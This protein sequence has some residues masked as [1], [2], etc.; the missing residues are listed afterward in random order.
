MHIESLPPEKLYA[1]TNDELCELDM[2]L[3]DEINR[4][5]DYRIT[6]VRSVLNMKV[7]PEGIKATQA[8]DAYR[9]KVRQQE[10]ERQKAQANVEVK[11]V[12]QIEVK[13]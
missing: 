10:A 6:Q 3:A 2:Q 7:A 11:G 4:L 8:I 9:R 1:M 5:G 13:A 12:P